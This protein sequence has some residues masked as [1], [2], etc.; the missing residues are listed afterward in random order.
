MHLQR[1]ALNL[2]DFRCHCRSGK[3]ADNMQVLQ[4]K[5][6][7]EAKGRLPSLHPI[8]G[9]AMDRAE[10]NLKLSPQ[11]KQ[12]TMRT[13]LDRVSRRMLSLQGPHHAC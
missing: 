7:A 12:S 4:R 1:S 11:K 8:R 6:T 13:G 2:S 3:G 10:H 5:A 9:R